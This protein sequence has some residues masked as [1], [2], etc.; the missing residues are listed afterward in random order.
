MKRRS[1]W[2]RAAPRWAGCLVKVRNGPRSPSRLDQLLD[3]AGA[4]RADQ[5][6]LQV[7]DADEGGGVGSGP[8]QAAAEIAFLP[9]VAQAGQ[10]DAEAAGA[11]QGHEVPDV[12][13]AAHRDH[14][15]ALAAQVTAGPFGQ[16]LHRGL[17][18]HPFDQHDRAR[19]RVAAGPRGRGGQRR[20]AGP[21]ASV[22][23]ASDASSTSSSLAAMKRSTERI[24]TTHV[25]SLPRPPRC[26][27]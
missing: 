27:T 14:E 2:S 8:A 19:A 5:L 11:E 16:S 23:A 24:Y 10:P 7:R 3:P 6:V 18:A 20:A 12:G 22:T 25:G 13:R 21:A 4:E 17:V 26:S 15:N 9:L 1:C